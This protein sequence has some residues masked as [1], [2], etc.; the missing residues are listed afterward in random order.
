MNDLHEAVKAIAAEI[1][2]N[3]HELDQRKAFLELDEADIAVLRQVHA[4]IDGDGDGLSDSFYQ[5]LLEFPQ[6]RALLPDDA[7]VARLR[8]TQ[9]A[10]FESLTAGDYGDDYVRGRLRVGLVH[11]RIG[12][13]PKWYLGAYRKYLSE[14]SK[15]LWRVLQRDPER[16]AAAR[17]AM[18]KVVFLDMGLALD[19]YFHADRR[20]IVQNQH[21]LEQIIDGMPAGLIVLDDA[22]KV[23]SM[24]PTMVALLGL[25]QATVGA[26]PTLGQL[27]PSAELNTCVGLVLAT[28]E[29]QDNVLVSLGDGDAVRYFK[30]NI[31]RTRQA[32]SHQLLLIAQ[33]VTRERAAKS[34]LLESEEHLRLTFSQAAVG[35]AH[36]ERDGRLIRVNRKLCDILGYSE[37]E[38]L[39]LTLQQ[40]NFR[41]DAE[42][43]Q[44]LVEQLVSGAISEYSRERRYATKSGQLL[45]VNVNVSSMCDGSGRLRFFSM[46]ED[47]SSR[48]RA[49]E[50]LLLVASQDV[51]TGLP[52]RLRLQS[53]LTHAITQAQLNGHQVAVMF[54][55]LDRFKH[56]ND[57]LGHDA[58]D[59]MIVEIARR[60]SSSLC[61]SDT[62]AR[63]GGDEFVVVL[64]NVGRADEAALVA[65]KLLDSL[66]PPMLLCGQEVFST[67]S[68]GLSMFPRDGLDGQTLLRSADSAMYLAKSSGG[69]NFR[70]YVPDVGADAGQRLRLEGAL[71]HALERDELVLHYQPQI[72]MCSGA[73]IGVEALVRWQPHGQ[74]MVAPADFIPLA[75]E[76]GLIVQIGEWVLDT[77][78]A[79]QVAWCKLGLP[80]IRM[81]VNLSARQ[82]HGQN[83]A[84]TV[85]LSLS[86][87]G[88][89][90]RWLTLEIT[91]SVVLRD[92]EAAI[93]TMRELAAMGVQLAIDDF[94]TGY[95]SLS[96]LKRFPIH[97]LKIDRSF[98]ADISAGGND[99]A[100][101]EAVIALA[102][103]MKLKV[104]AEGVETSEQHA[105]LS[106]HGCDQMQGYLFSRPVGA[107]QI[108]VLLAAQA[109]AGRPDR[110]V[111]E[112]TVLSS[113]QH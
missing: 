99:A 52:N 79:Q 28:G 5:H 38:L 103:S 58:G 48:K 96:Y 22:G 113:F 65:R 23:L 43:P 16:Y 95:S 14:T 31:R 78:C 35:I 59:R 68:I 54:I 74:P 8:K 50:A 10:Y 39:G 102:H 3:R 45:W 41:G 108:A 47:I 40:I 55:D 85:A 27:M 12:L 21:Y 69:N 24:N 11:Q 33:D 88:C 20:S 4:L 73:V 36:F 6:L 84:R 42:N 2:L 105:F 75:E 37:T 92:P 51:L 34:L 90:R 91:E 64:G 77:A 98:V 9:D 66:F 104:V 1:G 17:D 110:A 82:F 89:D 29:Q 61:D 57:S 67:A 62:L 7:T 49:E 107:D 87:S 111:C 94:G 19:T 44:V 25:D 71:R 18:L 93:E 46:I 70:F 100:I 60:L 76:T 63:Q 13:D 97:C 72:D 53:R 101:V 81:S 86:K 26:S 56:V 106:A 32:S 83:M 112:T 15:I 109:G 80:P 30:I